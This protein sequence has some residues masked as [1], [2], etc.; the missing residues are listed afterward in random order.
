MVSDIDVIFIDMKM[1]I[2]AVDEAELSWRISVKKDQVLV[3]GKV[4]E[5]VS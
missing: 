1:I 4:G 2:L 3:H 5:M